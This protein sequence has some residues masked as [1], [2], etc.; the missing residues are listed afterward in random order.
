MSNI[1]YTDTEPIQR[2]DGVT[3]A[4]RY[5]K[6]LCDY[7]FLSLWSYSGVFRDQWLSVSSKE[8]KEVCDLLVVFQEHIIIFSDKDCVF[9]DGD[10][11]DLNWRRWYKRAVLKSADQIWGAERWIKT[12][13]QRL[14][15]DT[16]CTQRFPINLPDSSIAKFHRILVAHGASKPCKD[17]FGGSGSLIIAPNVIGAMHCGSGSDGGR[18]FTIGQI[19]PTKGYVH[20]F[21]DTSLEI[22]MRTLDTI[23]DFVTYLTKKEQ[24]VLSGKLL[25][26]A[27]EDDL[28]AYYLKDI[29]SNGD[30]DFIV[31]DNAT[32][33]SINE[34]LWDMFASSP[35]R[36]A[37]LAANEVSYLWDMLIERFN[38]HILGGTQYYTSHPGIEYSE[39]SMRFLAREPRTR[40][41]ML[42]QSLLDMIQTTSSSMR[43]TR[44]ILPSRDGDPYYVFLLLPKWKEHSEAQYREVR[45]KLLEA[46]C[47]V[48]KLINPKAQDIIGIATETDPHSEDALYF[49][50][51]C[52]TR[53]Q[54][55][56]AQQLQHDLGLL[57]KL[58]Q[59][60]AIEKEY[61]DTPVLSRQTSIERTLHRM[62]GRDRNTPCPCGSGRKYKKCCGR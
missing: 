53:E 36:R 27:G 11:L 38:T 16:T 41:R 43:R 17:V 7:T 48:T 9:P 20:V 8:G 15:L 55:V 22:V 54:E 57:T 60:R 33:I 39:Q 19:D 29:N 42:A 18:P 35:Q 2:R 37:Q 49:D 51:R 31:P 62:K 5:L 12:N 59:F 3:T 61:P 40:R 44:V 1:N 58:T 25:W 34:G 45:L 30:H 50:A 21:D 13:P 46:C 56:E 52:W 47:L 32:A 24:F 28:L 6:R 10:D 14:F 4:E 23:T 26:A